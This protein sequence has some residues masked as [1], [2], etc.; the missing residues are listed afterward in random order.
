MV[1]RALEASLL[2][3]APATLT[4]NSEPAAADDTYVDWLLRYVQLVLVH[5]GEAAWRGACEF[6]E[7]R[8]FAARPHCVAS[9]DLGRFYSHVAE[10]AMA[11]LRAALSAGK[12]NNDDD[13]ELDCREA[14]SRKVLQCAVSRCASA[15][16]RLC[17]LCLIYSA[18]LAWN[19]FVLLFK[20]SNASKCQVN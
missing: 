13:G 12:H 9:L 16:N 5:Q 1:K 2:G 20:T 8:C 11:L 18:I 17:N 19:S 14:F 7:A 4:V 10:Q 15:G 6:V 3:R